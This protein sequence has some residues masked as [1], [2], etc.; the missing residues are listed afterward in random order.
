[1]TP[2]AGLN[3]IVRYL[4]PCRRVLR[5]EQPRRFDIIDLLYS[6]QATGDP[7]FP[8]ADPGFAVFVQLSSCRAD[9]TGRIE[10]VGADSGQTVGRSEVYD[11]ELGQSPLTIANIAI[12][13][14]DCVL[15]EGSLFLV[16][17][18]YNDVALAE[19]PLLVR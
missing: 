10:V 11:L 12:P 19:Q 15:P 6:I 14:R 1:M 3:P 9:G 17:F 5:Q 8:Y 4:I 18:C 2:G 13:V 16:R 7:R